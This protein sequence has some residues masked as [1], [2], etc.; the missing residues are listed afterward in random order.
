MHYVIGD[1]HGCF[2]EMMRLLETIEERDH[3]ARFIFTGDFID[4]G[5][6]VWKVLEWAR[7]HITRRGKYRSVRGNHEAMVIDWYMDYRIWFEKRRGITP[8]PMTMYDFLERVIEQNKDDPDLLEPYIQFFNSL[9]YHIQVRVPGKGKKNV[10]YDIVHA[11]M[12]PKGVTQAEKDQYYLWNRDDAFEGNRSNDHIVVHGHTP[13]TYE[14]RFVPESIPGMI[15]YRKNAV[16]IDGG[17]VFAPH[18]PEYPCMLCALCL[19]TLEEIY[20]YT[21][22]ERMVRQMPDAS[23]ELRDS[24]IKEYEARHEAYLENEFRSEI[25]SRLRQAGG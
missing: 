5:P 18:H 10:V 11:W 13:T 7:S 14:G 17:C 8:A 9:P 25:L 24:M 15:L 6:E 23:E 3:N 4:R 21:I 20:P 19:E 22:R 2:T 16:N 1:I 12:P